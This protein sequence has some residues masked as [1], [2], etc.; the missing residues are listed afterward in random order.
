LLLAIRPSGK[1]ARSRAEGDPAVNHA[2]RKARFSLLVE[3]TEGSGM[4][5]ERCIF[6]AL[7]IAVFPMFSSAMFF[8]HSVILSN[9]SSHR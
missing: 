4:S 1:S 9:M 8:I 5:I 2:A 3:M 7:E 6:A